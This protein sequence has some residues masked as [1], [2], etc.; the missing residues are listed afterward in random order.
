MKKISFIIAVVA[1]FSLFNIFSPTALAAT[2]TVT[3]D[4]QGA[5]ANSI[6][7]SNTVTTGKVGTLPTAPTRTGFTFGNWY[8]AING[9]GTK[10]SNS[11][12][13]TSNVTFYANWVG[14][15]TSYPGAPTI[16]F[17]S[18][19][20]DQNKV[21]VSFETPTSDGGFPITSYIIT[22]DPVGL[23]ATGTQSPIIVSGLANN[24]PYKFKVTARNIVGD[25]I[26]NDWTNTV[27]FGVPD[28]PTI[29]TAT[30]ITDQH[31]ATVSF[32][33]PA[34][35]G[36]LSISSYTITSNPAG[37][38]GTYNSAD[39][40]I[41][42]SG[43]VNNQKY[44]FTVKATNPAG[45]SD[46]SASSNGVEI[47]APNAPVIVYASLIDNSNKAVIYFL[48]PASDGGL[49]VSSYTVVS[50][51]GGLTAT[52]TISP[53]TVSGLLPDKTYTF[54][55]TATNPAGTSNP[56][57]DPSGG[58][59]I[60][61]PSAP[62]IGSAILVDGQSK[63][64]FNAPLSNGASPISSYS[65][66]SS[67]S[68]LTATGAT[69][70]ITVSG[71]GA[72][73]KY[74]FAV[75]ATN[76]NSKTSDLSAYSN[77][78]KIGVPEKPI[79]GAVSLMKEPQNVGKAIVSFS[80]SLIDTPDTNLI[81]TVYSS[82]GNLK[83][84]GTTSPIIVSGLIRDISYKFNVEAETIK[85]TSPVSPWSSPSVKQTAPLAPTAVVAAGWVWGGDFGDIKVSWTPAS[86]GGSE[87]ISYK[88]FANG[89][90]AQDVN[91]NPVIA[92]SSPVR[93][94]KLLSG[95]AYKFTVSATNVIGT[96]PLSSASAAIT[97]STVSEPPASLGGCLKVELANGDYYYEC[98]GIQI[99]KTAYVMFGDYITNFSVV[100]S[101]ISWSYYDGLN[102]IG[103]VAYSTDL[104]S[105][106][107]STRPAPQ[108][109]EGE[110]NT[111]ACLANKSCESTDIT[112]KFF[113]VGIN[114]DSATAINHTKFKSWTSDPNVLK[115]GAQLVAS[116]A[117]TIVTAGAASPI[118]YAEIAS[119]ISTFDTTFTVISAVSV[120]NDLYSLAGYASDIVGIIEKDYSVKAAAGKGL[121]IDV[122]SNIKD[123]STGDS[124]YVL[125]DTIG[126]QLPKYR[127]YLYQ[128]TKG[129]ADSIA[130]DPGGKKRDVNSAV[131]TGGCDVYVSNTYVGAPTSYS[132]TFANV[133]EIG[134]VPA[135]RTKMCKSQIVNNDYSRV[136]WEK[137]TGDLLDVNTCGAGEISDKYINGSGFA[138]A[139]HID[140][141][142][143][144][145]VVNVCSQLD[146][147]PSDLSSK[148]SSGESFYVM[149]N[150]SGSWIP[151]KYPV[152]QF[153]FGKAENS[154]YRATGSKR[155]YSTVDYDGSCN[156]GFKVQ[157]SGDDTDYPN[158]YVSYYETGLVNK[159]KCYSSIIATQNVSRSEYPVSYYAPFL[160]SL[161]TCLDESNCTLSPRWTESFIA[162]PCEVS[163]STG[164]LRA[165]PS[166]IYSGASSTLTWTSGASSTRGIGSWTAN[167]SPNGSQ[168]VNN[169]L[170][171]TSYS[172]SF[173]TGA[174]TAYA[175][176]TVTV[177]SSPPCSGLSTCPPT[178]NYQILD[179]GIC[180]KKVALTWAPVANATGYDVYRS[181]TDPD[182]TASYNIIGSGPLNAF[183]DMNVSTSSTYYYRI[184]ACDDRTGTRI[185]SDLSN[186]TSGA[187][188]PEST[189]PI[190][191]GGTGDC[192]VVNATPFVLNQANTWTVNSSC[193]S[194]TYEWS[195]TG[196]T[197]SIST[198]AVKSLRK[199]YTTLGIKSIFVD[200]LNDDGTSYCDSQAMATTTVI[201]GDSGTIER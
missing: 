57:S 95:T 186:H 4:N 32:T 194:C 190:C 159:A 48:P 21:S 74:K 126:S 78:V 19:T 123:L 117:L 100:G 199:I 71:L 198:G 124:F 167:T 46:P 131:Y 17:A 34:S 39:N 55:V 112:K 35:D 138:E 148:I 87:V 96:S 121:A 197:G 195:G 109:V 154:T 15:L 141:D 173:I 30:L 8:T 88:V 145:P 90:Q 178:P 68:G 163:T 77:Q 140:R 116:V 179:N 9:G 119:L 130:F 110:L 75:K 128:F 36:G 52:G 51:P 139:V 83:A 102:K 158:A 164:T 201:S 133:V 72:D 184:K 84:T 98:N 118:I 135:D 185:C 200:V 25:K 76:N 41:T 23:T 155:I 14:N 132:A 143:G 191:L 183:T 43:L 33:P 169:I 82:T 80:P 189:D 122:C 101:V 65:V 108:C 152:Y 6:P 11:T 111:Y 40:T 146:I 59:E 182:N 50:N 165:N 53:I 13:V 31:K 69:S 12:A 161:R 91:G 181:T 94:G 172:M 22:S 28:K 175:T 115:L 60:G 168:V 134:K 166:T 150:L 174:D 113:N 136:F 125:A 114:Y 27:T 151:M 7:T 16:G 79:I 42:V 103:P 66:V 160:S 20:Q 70:P 37:L 97:G 45:T 176:A 120:A 193:P 192:T 153:T 81:Y 171:T 73:T 49:S 67:P 18:L 106:D 93:V 142:S 107:E 105:C 44:S 92:S 38:T 5:T 64:Y 149:E 2:Y 137:Q 10:I 187:I 54:T 157:Y 63:V 62:I 86:D 196:I 85:G 156:L 89:I 147:T 188:I 129:T 61:A 58:L 56:A 26:S 29:G 104:A 180:A 99:T 127:Y 24:V 3:F 144:W 47:T 170:D 1:I 162:W 177:L